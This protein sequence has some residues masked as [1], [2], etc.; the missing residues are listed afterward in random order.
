MSASILI[1]EPDSVVANLVRADAEAAGYNLVSATQVADA[2]RHLRAWDFDLVLCDMGVAVGDAAVEVVKTAKFMSHSTEIIVLAQEPNV[3]LALTCLRVG[4]FELLSYPLDGERLTLSIEVA[5]ERRR[6]ALFLESENQRLSQRIGQGERFYTL[7]ELVAGLG[8][9]VNTPVA[10]ILANQTFVTNELKQLRTKLE[11]LKQTAPQAPLKKFDDAYFAEL[12]SALQD[13]SDAAKRVSALATDLTQSMRGQDEAPKVFDL[14]DSIRA[15]TRI[16]NHRI[17]RT[18]Q[19][20][21]HCGEEVQVLGNPSKLTQ[22][23]INLLVNAAQALEARRDGPRELSIMTLRTSEEVMA[24]VSDTGLGISSENLPR[25]FDALFTTKPSGEGTG[26]GLSISRDIVA[27]YGGDIY[28]ESQVG[29][30]TTFTVALPAASPSP[31]SPP[32]PSPH[33]PSTH[34]PAL[35]PISSS[36]ASSY[37]HLQKH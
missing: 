26:L 27:R 21:M 28:V 15:A 5:G 10:C 22:V 31:P 8:H 17:G 25:V 4:A 2:L 7:G 19:V 36:S 24:A 32:S 18:I 23:F 6:R 3:E 29:S 37:E 12:N 20:R 1:V 11:E 9:E 16:A 14:N 30:G 35:H 33:A 13:A 34:A